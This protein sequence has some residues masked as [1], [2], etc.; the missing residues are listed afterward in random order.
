[1]YYVKADKTD[2]NGN[3]ECVRYVAQW[4]TCHVALAGM[5][6]ACA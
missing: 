4:R 5:N 1:M 2:K 6:L 3:T